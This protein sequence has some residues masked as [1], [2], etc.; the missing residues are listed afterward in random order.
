MVNE[1]ITYAIILYIILMSERVQIQSIMFEMESRKTNIDGAKKI[2][3]TA[4][5]GDTLNVKYP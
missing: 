1:K 2:M 5:S 4:V 3:I